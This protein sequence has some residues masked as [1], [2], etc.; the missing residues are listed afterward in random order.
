MA[1]KIRILFLRERQCPQSHILLGFDQHR[2]RIRSS[3]GYQH[4][5]YHLIQAYPIAWHAHVEDRET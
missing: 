3:L 4:E 2:P 5:E 1:T